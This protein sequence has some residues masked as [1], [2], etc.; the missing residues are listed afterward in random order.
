MNFYKL[1]ADEFEAV[2]KIEKI[3]GCD[4][5]LLGDFIPT[6]C[7]IEMARDILVMYEKLQEEF[8]DYKQFVVDN[9]KQ[10]SE[11]ELVGN[12]ANW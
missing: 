7:L 6:E 10:K 1:N 11:A 2:K 8:I 4:Y 9:F 3:T 12:P 5:E